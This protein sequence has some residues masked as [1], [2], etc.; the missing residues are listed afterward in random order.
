MS[1]L[2]N[3]GASGLKAYSRALATVSDNIA[4]AQT[5]G[6][7]RRT[8]E[9]REAPAAGDI[10][11]SRNGIR[12]GG[13]EASGVRR[14][15]DV[16]LAEDARTASGEA[17]R[18]ATRLG[19]MEATERALDDGPGGIGQSMTRIFTT[20]DQLAAD[21]ANAVLRA[22][23]LQA[24]DDSAAAFRRTAGA[25]E[26]AAGGVAQ[27]AGAAVDA[28]N[29]DLAALEQV[30]SGLRRARAGSSNEATLLDERDRLLDRISST[31]PVDTS[32]DA[33]GAVT[34][35]AKDGGYPL[36]A[37]GSVAALSLSVQADG[38]L[39]FAATPGGLLSPSGGMLAGLAQG[40]D[41]IS[42]QRSALDGLA[43]QF[44]GELN[45][46]HQAGF[47]A[48]GNSGTILLTGTSAATLAAAA[49]S[50]DAVAAAD[51]SGANG[52]ALNLAN[53]R[54][55]NG[56]EAGW[57]ALVGQQA[58][59]AASARAQDAA[60]SSRRDGAFAARDSVSEVDLDHEAAELLRF[61]QAYEAAARTV[62]VA[63]ETMQSILNIF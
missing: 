12:P 41:H 18:S 31:L 22:Q 17:D 59:Q 13:V 47:D 24:V 11:L 36:L 16:W 55:T 46:W 20:A 43:A 42:G 5:P 61:Q 34:L 33:R 9:L 63:R 10:V 14:S 45:G 1:D 25:L 23:F 58:Q 57:A 21:P 19:A 8:A 27:A 40:A 52:N 60:A 26:N 35:T 44:A 2:L 49:L 3:I 62:Q 6:Y 30:N 54:G 7:A 28:L 39:G 50:A 32:F 38:R 15:V 4:N 48:N 53:L 51:G 37:G 29:T 56:V